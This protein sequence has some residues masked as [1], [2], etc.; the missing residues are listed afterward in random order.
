MDDWFYVG[1]CV[2]SGY[3]WVLDILLSV[4]VLGERWVRGFGEVRGLEMVLIENLCWLG[5]GGMEGYYRY[6]IGYFFFFMCMYI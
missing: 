3:L 6:F 4:I 5:E 1:G 2:G